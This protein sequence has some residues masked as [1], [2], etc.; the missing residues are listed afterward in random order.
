MTAKRIYGSLFK[1]LT[2]ITIITITFICFCFADSF[3]PAKSESAAANVAAWPVPP[4]ELAVSVI[5]PRELLYEPTNLILDSDHLIFAKAGDRLALKWRSDP[6]N[7]VIDAPEFHSSDESV[8]TVNADGVVTAKGWGYCKILAVSGGM[9]AECSVSVAKKWVALT[10]DDGPRAPTKPFLAELKKR[11]V[12]VTFFILGNLAETKAWSGNIVQMAKDGHDIGNHS[13]DHGKDTSKLPGQVKH[14]DNIVKGLTGS[15]TQFLRPPY[16]IVSEDAKKCSKP[17]I[18][19]NDDSLDW[20]LRDPGKIYAGVKKE[21]ASG[22]III[23][24][25]IYTTTSEAVLKLI[26]SLKR[27]GFAFVTVSDMLGKMSDGEVYHH[28]SEKVR[29]TKSPNRYY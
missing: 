5:M 2:L 25:D 15:N 19:W 7:S 29:T 28:G 24:H 22:D 20:N 1:R 3:F 6:E 26:P 27:D 17:I 13:Y 4:P 8:A 18:L 21:V 14:T 9:S 12:H 10:F 11:D 16:G 23:F